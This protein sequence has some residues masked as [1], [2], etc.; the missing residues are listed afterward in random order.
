M[1]RW[2]E[3]CGVGLPLIY[4]VVAKR[5]TGLD[6][7]VYE[8]DPSRCSLIRL[9][10]ALSREETTELLVQEEFADAPFLV[11]IAGNLVGACA[12]HGAHGH[13]QLLLRAG[14]AGHTFLMAA[15]SL[16]LRG[17]LVAGLIPGAA[18]KFLGLDGHRRASLLAVAAGNP[19]NATIPKVNSE[20]D[21]K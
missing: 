4:L 17:S 5:V 8:Y 7:G 1:E 20:S 11:W 12:R 16:N 19:L 18:R 10:S 3:D 2:P 6:A 13:R 9:A 15:L 14:A 21:T